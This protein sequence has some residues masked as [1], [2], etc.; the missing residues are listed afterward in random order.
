MKANRIIKLATVTALVFSNIV[1]VNVLSTTVKAED[2]GT[3]YYVSTLD[4]KDSNSGKSEKD[5]FYSLQKINELDLKPGDKILLEKGSVF[6]DGYLHLYN[7]KG[8]KENPII[9]DSYGE[10]ANPLIETNG[11][12]VWFQ[13][14]G[15]L[16]DNKQHKAS[17]YVSSSILLYDTEY[18]EVKNISMTNESLEIDTRYNA[19]DTMNRTGVAVVAQDN[20]TLDHIYLNNLDIK[21]VKGNV[22][23][24]HMNNGGIYFTIFKPRDNANTE[25]PRYNDVLIENCKLDNVN[26][27]GIA[28]GYTAYYDNFNASEISDEAIAKYGSTN[29]VIKNNYIKD[30]GG[31]AI[32]TMYCDRPLIEYN[33][34]DGAAKQINTT[35]YSETSFGRVAAGIWPWKCKN[36]VFQYNEVFDTCQNQDGQAWDADSGDGTLYQYNYSHNNGGGAVMFCLDQSVNNTFRYNISQNDLGGVINPTNNPDAH[37]YNNVFYVKEGVPFIRPGMSGGNMV[38]ENNIIYNSGEQARTEDWY[39]QT[40]QQKVKYD[41]NLYYNY[42]NT[43]END[44]NAVNVEAGTQV[45]VDPGKAPTAPKATVNERSAFDGYKLCENSPAINAGKIISDANGYAV[46]KDFFGNNAKV[47]SPD[48]GAYESNTIT[49]AL[50]SDVYTID[51]KENTITGLGKDTTVKEFIDN[52]IYD[53]GIKVTVKDEN[54]KKLSDED[55]V[56]GNCIVSIT[57]GKETKEYTFTLSSDAKIHSSVFEIKDNIINV[58]SVEKNPTSLQTV[59]NGIE[60][61]EWA[62]VTFTKDNKEIKD[63]N[64]ED[65]MVM[66]ITAQDKNT[67]QSYTINVK[68]D[69]NYVSDFT[70]NQQGNVWF[71]Q[72]KAKDGAYSNMTTYNADWVCWTGTDWSS[73]GLDTKAQG[74]SKGLLCD[75]LTEN[76][77]QGGYSMAYRVPVNGTLTLTFEDFEGKGNVYLR[78]SGNNGGEAYVKL[79]LNGQD[80]TDMIRVPDDQSGVELPDKTIEVKQGD[81]IRIEAINTGNPKQASM[82][83]TPIIKYE[84]VEPSL[85]EVDKT[86]LQAKVNEAK[87][88][89]KDEY[90]PESFEKVLTALEEA[91]KVLAN[92]KVTQ[93]EVNNALNMLDE[94]I[95]QLEVVTPEDTT[96]PTAPT[97]LEVY[98]IGTT[99]AKLSWNIS[100][101][102]VGVV[103]Y[104]VALN[105]EVIGQINPNSVTDSAD[106]VE[107][108]LKNLTQNTQYLV[109]VS[110]FDEAGNE[111]EK[112]SVE[113]KTLEET[114]TP[115]DVDKS[116]LQELYDKYKDLQN[117]NYTDNSWNAFKDA[118]ANAKSVL[119]N[120][121]ATQTDI[122]NAVDLLTK[123]AN[124]LTDKDYNNQNK[125][126]K[127]SNNNN[128]SN[129]VK[130]GDNNIIL[131]LL[132][133]M[134]LAVV[135]VTSLLVLKNKKRKN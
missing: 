124:G 9:I 16:L 89:N 116:K 69:Y 87:A 38:V 10:G 11:Q 126:S 44:K 20:G 99:T 90:T 4:G 27:W 35:D 2:L 96:P 100:Q 26:R 33:V 31:D 106:K 57:D 93:E 94:A 110:A 111:S 108:I 30:A 91:E 6:T 74:G 64:V 104:N 39:K 54:D 50:A 15:K 107:A 34:S 66:T 37:I 121:S 46:D 19:L 36:A 55:L 130:T 112:A 88:L 109:E 1:P 56:N 80:L 65:K 73:V 128:S 47:S 24:K 68:N 92:E 70:P 97:N 49:L 29:V 95:K 67:E 79:T 123:S 77:R 85:P 82:H 63:G 40:S 125:P 105:G 23:D 60:I 52:L 134:G 129:T 119:D 7:Q 41:N 114:V 115:S 3:T 28:V 98:N 18:V 58:P 131:E 14:Y 101:D 22:Y 75:T 118:L 51:N 84:N 127:P 12:G 13:N 120:E 102:D 62:T 42:A 83:I 86:A 81:Y 17:G 45:F 43:P 76:A 117:Q 53:E 32:T 78:N 71:A 5:A 122:D 61:N 135:F 103:G 21:N 59:L 133:T 113:F 48:I 132:S 72:S 8:S 25:I